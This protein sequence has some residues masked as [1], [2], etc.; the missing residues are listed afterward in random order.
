MVEGP[1]I[2]G[3]GE[4]LFR[5]CV[6]CILLFA[7]LNVL[8]VTQVDTSKIYSSSAMA[9]NDEGHQIYETS[10]SDSLPSHCFSFYYDVDEKTQTCTLT[11]LAQAQ[12][13]KKT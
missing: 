3:Y 2:G 4:S 13:V 1:E 10:S 11:P 9:V 6:L 12:N 7:L 8:S 5:T